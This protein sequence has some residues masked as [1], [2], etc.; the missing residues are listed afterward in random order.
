[1]FLPLLISHFFYV[2]DPTACPPPTPGIPSSE[3]KKT[4]RQAYTLTSAQSGVLQTVAL[5]VAPIV[6]LLSDR[7]GHALTLQV[8]SLAALAGFLMYGVALPGEGDP[9][10]GTAWGAAVL[11]G[12]VRIDG[13]ERQIL[14]TTADPSLSC[15]P[16]VQAQIICIV[17]SLS[18]VSSLKASLTPSA[19]TAGAIAGAYSSTGALSI[20]LFS[21]IGGWLFDLRPDGPFLILAGASG[22]VALW[23]GFVLIKQRISNR[24]GTIR[25]EGEE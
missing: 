13:D 5:I 22:V 19:K 8:G 23:G 1:M 12:I 9:R 10:S 14:V 2:T 16:Y 4:C 11:L 24:G 7:V 17:S 20:L 15:V 21:S 3:L 18:L 25:L 6:G